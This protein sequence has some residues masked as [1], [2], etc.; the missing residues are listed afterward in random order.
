MDESEKEILNNFVDNSNTAFLSVD[1]WDR[2][3]N[4]AI[5]EID[6]IEGSDPLSINY[7]SKE[8]LKELRFSIKQLLKRGELEKE[9]LKKLEFQFKD[10]LAKASR[11]EVRHIVSLFGRALSQKSE[12][13]SPSEPES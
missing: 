9:T 2:Q 13:K 3:V 1:W 5:R 10:I 11:E 6:E 7:E 4:E 8:R 12:T